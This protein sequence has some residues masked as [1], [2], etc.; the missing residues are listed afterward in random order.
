MYTFM[1]PTNPESTNQRTYKRRAF[2]VWINCPFTGHVKPRPSWETNW[3]DWRSLFLIYAVH[4]CR[5]YKSDSYRIGCHMLPELLNL[6]WHGI[7]KT[8]QRRTEIYSWFFVLAM[9]GEEI[10]EEIKGIGIGIELTIAGVI[11]EHTGKIILQISSPPEHVYKQTRK[12]QAM[13]Y[14]FYPIQR[15]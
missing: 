4:P 13:Q 10:A 1:I 2:L 15:L 9:P 3:L 5:E 7:T 11:S 14:N 8:R 12:G 6:A